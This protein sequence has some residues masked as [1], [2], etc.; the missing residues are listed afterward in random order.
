MFG[1]RRRREHLGPH[2]VGSVL[3]VVSLVIGDVLVAGG[4][5]VVDTLR[6]DD[7][8]LSAAFDDSTICGIPGCFAR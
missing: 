8:G 3:A 4:F 7:L 2:T 5:L 1:V 6:L